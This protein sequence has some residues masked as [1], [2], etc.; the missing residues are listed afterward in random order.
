MQSKLFNRYV[1]LVDL[2]NTKE[3]LT[4]NEID[5]E[6]VKSQLGDGKSFPLRTFHQHRTAIEELFGIEIACDASNGHKYYIANPDI[7]KTDK[8]RKW[9]IESFSVANML[10]AG[11]NMRK[12]IV[13]E[14]VAKKIHYLPIVIEALQNRREIQLE[15]QPIYGNRTA[16]RLQPYAMKVHDGV[17][18][19]LGKDVEHDC[20][21]CIPLYTIL[22]M[23]IT[24]QPYK[25]PDDFRAEEYFKDTIGAT[26]D[27]ASEPVDVKIRVFGTLIDELEMCQL[28]SSQERG[29]YKYQEFAEYK[30][31]LR[32]SPELTTRLLSMGENVEV[33]EPAALRNEVKKRLAEALGRYDEGEES[34]LH[35]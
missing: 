26:V 22:E 33:L 18:Y 15:H 17:W 13:F 1:W 14:P 34:I 7:L 23:E 25:Y 20:I 2:L 24:E 3:A 21:C 32:L 19:V 6:W 5:R 30:Y 27:L 11:H 28:H 8:I 29:R 10:V 31:K 4:Y 12:Y 16:L 35:V 9:L